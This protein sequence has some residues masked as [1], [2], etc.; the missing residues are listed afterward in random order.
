MCWLTKKNK[1]LEVKLQTGCIYIRRI[2]PLPGSPRQR[3]TSQLC[4][5]RPYDSTFQTS[6]PSSPNLDILSVSQKSFPRTGSRRFQTSSLVDKLD[7]MKHGMRK[8]GSLSNI[9]ERVRT[10]RGSVRKSNSRTELNSRSDDV[11]SAGGSENSSLK[12]DMSVNLTSE[13]SPVVIDKERK[14]LK[15]EISSTPFAKRSHSF[16]FNALHEA[17]SLMSI[18]ETKE[19][20][21]DS[22][23]GS[24]T[25]KYDKNA[26]SKIGRISSFK[27][28]SIFR[29]NVS[30]T[31]TEQTD[32]CRNRSF[33][34]KL[35]NG[36]LPFYSRSKSENK[37]NWEGKGKS[38]NGKESDSQSELSISQTNF[39]DADITGRCVS[40][41]L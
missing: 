2:S 13:A 27:S 31:G 23:S 10:L 1:I 39:D 22:H 30:E 5:T 33:L 26:K 34:Q 8:A 21:H 15:G 6:S 32:I 28:M 19:S 38:Q 17:T 29:R 11:S 4:L 41:Y 16:E 25:L 9:M 18:S 20:D 3:A 36:K 14:S 35:W 12:G 24:S 37:L 7:S 40:L